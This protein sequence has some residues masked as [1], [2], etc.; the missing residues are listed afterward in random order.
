[1]SDLVLRINKFFRVATKNEVNSVIDQLVLTDRQMKIL[2]MFYLQKR[3]I[4]YIAD[5]IG[6]CSNVVDRELQTIR[7]KIDPL[8]P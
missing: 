1:M 6:F 5:E 4:D 8:I 3:S 7:K 2:T